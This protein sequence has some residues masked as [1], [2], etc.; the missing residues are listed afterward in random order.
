MFILKQ[1][2]GIQTS[3]TPTR[4]NTTIPNICIFVRDDIGFDFGYFESSILIFS[5]FEINISEVNPYYF[6]STSYKISSVCFFVAVMV[7]KIELQST[8]IMLIKFSQESSKG[9]VIYAGTL[10]VCTN[11]TY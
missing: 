5:V 1:E 9:S 10:N 2:I 7:R 3:I 8:G 4:H 11:L 6:Y